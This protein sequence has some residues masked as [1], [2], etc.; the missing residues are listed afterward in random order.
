MGVITNDQGHESQLDPHQSLPQGLMTH[1]LRFR[2]S[3]S[4]VGPG[5][6]YLRS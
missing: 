3:K 4:G 2:F 1:G 5:N 6:V